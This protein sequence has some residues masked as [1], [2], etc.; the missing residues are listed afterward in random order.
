MFEDRKT[1]IAPFEVATL[2]T[3]LRQ[4][5]SSIPVK[6]SQEF[7]MFSEEGKVQAHRQQDFLNDAQ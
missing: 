3:E 4:Q 5:C 6:A 7:E 2:D 1:K